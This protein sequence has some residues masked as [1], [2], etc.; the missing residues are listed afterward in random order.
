[1]NS[2]TFIWLQNALK[3]HFINHDLKSS[4]LVVNRIILFFMAS[5]LAIHG[6]S[7]YTEYRLTME[8]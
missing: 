3:L 8:N 1:M 5:N 6:T 7:G 2:K 4:L